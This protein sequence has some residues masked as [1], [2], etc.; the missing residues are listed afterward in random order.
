LGALSNLK[1]LVLRLGPGLSPKA[2]EPLGALAKLERL[3]LYRCHLTDEHLAFLGRLTS[4][5]ELEL[6]ENPL[7]GDCLAHLRGLPQLQRLSVLECTDFDERNLR[8]VAAIA[9]LTD[10]NLQYTPVTDAGLKALH[11]MPN[12]R[13]VL[14]LRSRVTVPAKAALKAT[15]PRGADVY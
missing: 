14:L 12:L 5:R 2:L 15:L 1:E 7:R 4:L 13:S 10:V 11:G 8:H 3:S 9:S 6:G